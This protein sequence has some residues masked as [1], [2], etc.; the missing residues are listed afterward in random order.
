MPQFQKLRELLEKNYSWPAPYLFKFIIPTEKEGEFKKILGLDET[1]KQYEVR[2][3]GRGKYLSFTFS[4]SIVHS[5]EVIEV[6]QKAITI[7]GV[8]SL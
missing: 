3:S 2:A 1:I 7:Q 5:D 8:L 6:Y 4:M